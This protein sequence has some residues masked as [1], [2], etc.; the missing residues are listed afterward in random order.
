MK[1]EKDELPSDEEKETPEEQS[2]EKEEGTEAHEDSFKDGVIVPEDFQKS[3]YACLKDAT[4]QEL[5]F[6]SKLIYKLQ[7]EIREE[8]KKGPAEFSSVDEPSYD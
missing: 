1:S 5:D 4:M 6:V 7:D 8:E 2:K 3:I